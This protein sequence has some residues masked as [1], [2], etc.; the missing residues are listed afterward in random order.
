MGNKRSVMLSVDKDLDHFFTTWTTKV[1]E[2]D[3]LEYKQN[4][5]KTALYNRALW[6]AVERAD[7][8]LISKKKED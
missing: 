1:V 6:F 4:M 3:G 5:N 7:Q 8:W 2:I